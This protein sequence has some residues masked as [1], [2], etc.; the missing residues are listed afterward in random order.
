MWILPSKPKLGK[1]SF[2]TASSET[3]PCSILGLTHSSSVRANARPESQLI[4]RCLMPRR[5]E[6][7]AA[8]AVA[9]DVPEIS[10]AEMPA[11]GFSELQRMR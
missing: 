4:A 9:E 7:L 1:F 5:T 10:E 6:G 3:A 2:G 8:I 11:V